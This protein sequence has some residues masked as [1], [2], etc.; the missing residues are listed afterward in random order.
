VLPYL[1][2]GIPKWE[3]MN[4]DYPLKHI[5]EPSKKLISFAEKILKEDYI[6]K[7]NS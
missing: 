4:L 7:K 1:K 5:K 6:Y 3:Q 2:H